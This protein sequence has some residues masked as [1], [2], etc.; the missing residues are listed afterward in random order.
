MF[1]AAV[2][3][4]VGAIPE[5]LPAAV[6]ITL[7]IGVHR[8]AQRR[9]VVRRMPAVETL[10]STTVICSD[11][12][13]TLTENQ[14][15]VRAIWTPSD[16][17]EVTGSGYQPEGVIL[18]PSGAAVD[19]A[20]DE[21]LRWTLLVGAACNDAW[22]S[23]ADGTWEVIGDPTEG[24]VLVAAAKAGIDATW[25][26]QRFPRVAAVPFSSERKYMATLHE[27]VEAGRVVCRERRRRMH[28]RS[29]R[30]ADGS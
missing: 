16:V 20:G 19:L 8:M 6:T 24:A 22:L 14:M 12:T 17:F 25:V 7:A 10:G 4:A 3:L 9:A 27:N 29:V 13:G 18:G 30:L 11:K 21:A 5:G 26:R 28:R 2:A 15:T 1:N 23:D